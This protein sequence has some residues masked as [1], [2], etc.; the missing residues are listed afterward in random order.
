MAD[1]NT[2]DKDAGR[3]EEVGGGSGEEKEVKERSDGEQAPL[4][5]AIPGPVDPP[6]SSTQD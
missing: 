5:G 2:D 1:D 3:G 4:P 6:E